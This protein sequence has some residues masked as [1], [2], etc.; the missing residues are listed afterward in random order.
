MYLL[1]WIVHGCH[2]LSSSAS[3]WEQG[4]EAFINDSKYVY[5][6]GNAHQIRP[7]LNNAYAMSGY[8]PA[9]MKYGLVFEDYCH[10]SFSR[11]SELCGFVNVVH[12]EE[13]KEEKKKKAKSK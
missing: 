9:L 4:S 12:N 11:I 6:K 8:H 5:M 2:A 13:R 7:F 1:Y 10:L 3:L